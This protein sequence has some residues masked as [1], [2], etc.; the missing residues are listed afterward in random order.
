MEDST[1]K[2]KPMTIQ[3]AYYDKF[4]LFFSDMLNFLKVG[5]GGSTPFDKFLFRG[6]SSAKFK[7]LPT[8]LREFPNNLL[9]ANW[10]KYATRSEGSQIRCEYFS[11]WEFYKNANEQGL[12]IKGSKFMKDE[13]LSSSVQRFGF[14]EENYK[15][16]SDEYVELA[17]I[18]QHYGVP[19][20]LLDWTSDFLTSLYFASSGAIKQ[21][22]RDK[23]DCSDKMVLWVLNGAM[24]HQMTKPFPLKLVVPPYYDNPNLNAQK[25]VLSYWEIEMP[26]RT[27]EATMPVDIR[28]LD[29]QLQ[30]HDMGYDA[31]HIN[32]LYRVEIDINECEYMYSAVSDLGYNA[33]KLFPGYDGVRIKME[34]DTRANLFRS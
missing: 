3:T 25:G 10:P 24:I 5:R 11:L 9:T 33:A 32:I 34:D 12:K 8:A 21:W 6:E 30:E 16:L 17:A 7:L 1:V 22:E 14:Q 27:D 13:Y 23:Y 2:H 28:P 19:T 29:I 15:W 26:G 4:D 20:R 18:A 31:A